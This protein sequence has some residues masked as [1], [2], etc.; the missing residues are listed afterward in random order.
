[1]STWNCPLCKAVNPSPIIPCQ[2]VSCGAC[3][4]DFSLDLKSSY[5]IAILLPKKESLGIFQIMFGIG[6][7]GCFIAFATQSGT[8]A[9]ISAGLI[10][11]WYI[12]QEF[13]K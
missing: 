1:M 6:F 3:N 2:K 11:T 5:P 9:L 4:N 10:L 8:I 7:F 13:F 12:R